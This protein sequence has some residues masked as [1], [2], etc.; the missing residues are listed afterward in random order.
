MSYRQTNIKALSQ[1]ASFAQCSRKTGTGAYLHLKFFMTSLRMSPG[2]DMLDGALTVTF[3]CRFNA[4]EKLAL[5]IFS[6]EEWFDIRNR[7]RVW[8]VDKILLTAVARTRCSSVSDI[9]HSHYTFTDSITQ[10]IYQTKMWL[11]IK[12]LHYMVITAAIALLLYF[13][14][15]SQ[16]H[17]LLLLLFR[18]F[19]IDVLY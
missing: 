12:A 18:V 19:I 9:T 8:F 3:G 1:I 15:D 4:N 11:R 7:L 6:S 5:F 17:T 13:V 14:C 10:L 16:T 2:F